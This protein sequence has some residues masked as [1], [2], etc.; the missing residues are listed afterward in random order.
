MLALLLLTSV[1][2]QPITS[3]IWRALKW[4]GILGWIISDEVIRWSIA[5]TGKPL[6]NILAGRVAVL[7]AAWT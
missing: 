6:L 2:R 5:V 7:V 1:G 3:L 4:A